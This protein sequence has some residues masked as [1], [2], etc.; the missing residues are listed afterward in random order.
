MEKERCHEV[1]GVGSERWI[2]QQ[3]VIFYWRWWI[4]VGYVWCVV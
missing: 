4:R 2:G 1:V 3:E